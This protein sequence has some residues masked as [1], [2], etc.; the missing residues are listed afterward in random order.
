MQNNPRRWYPFLYTTVG[1][2]F[3]IV[4]HHQ[5]T[6]IASLYKNEMKEPMTSPALLR[7]Q[8]YTSNHSH[9]PPHFMG[10]LT[11]G[12]PVIFASVIVQSAT[13][14]IP[15]YVVP[16]ACI[17]SQHHE[18]KKKEGGPDTRSL[19]SCSRRYNLLERS[20]PYSHR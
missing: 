18:G 7:A 12:I 15:S 14:I 10:G 6:T 2:Y 9:G 5:P 8:S 1:R 19:G 20:A 11:V 17:E 3:V 4:A 13:C 16:R